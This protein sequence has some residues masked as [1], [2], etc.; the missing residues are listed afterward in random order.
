VKTQILTL[1]P[2]DDQAAARD[3][4][5]WT[6]APRVILVW[7]ARGRILNRR[8]DL[9]L[10]Q[11]QASRRGAQIGLVTLDPDIR[12]E[13]RDLGIPAFKSLDDVS[14]EAWRT[15]ALRRRQTTPS[16][17]LP[18]ADRPDLATLR[19]ALP[20]GRDLPLPGRWA[21]FSLAIIAV[22]LLGIS[23]LPSA[24]ITLMPKSETQELVLDVLPQLAAAAP[25]ATG[26]IPARQVR[27]RILGEMQQPATGQVQVPVSYASGTAIF[28]NLS[29]DAVAIPA[30][31]GVRTLSEP[32]IR[33]RTTEEVSLPAEEGATVIVPIQALM[34]GSSGNLGPGAIEAI[35]GNLG[36]Q[37]SVSNPQAIAGGKDEIRIGVAQGDLD[38]LTQALEQDLMHK[39]LQAKQAELPEDETLDEASLQ[40]T[41]V[42]GR[43]FSHAVGEA[44][45]ILRL[46]LDLEVAG[47]VYREQDLQEAVQ[48][49]LVGA[50]P[51]GRAPIP[52]SLVINRTGNEAPGQADGSFQIHAAQELFHP[53]DLGALGRAIAGKTQDEAIRLL[54][55]DFSLSVQKMRLFPAWWPRLPWLQPRMT[56][57]WSWETQ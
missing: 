19:H 41:Q 2:T 4:L 7:P 22:L 28:T 52:D 39:A 12:D 32:S 44:T 51:S 20:K 13:A 43:Q 17:S 11:R 15:R 14:E 16:L 23:L 1:E 53:V 9:A 5:T 29:Q 47:L 57:R 42:Y 25:Q 56:V 46:T 54:E 27:M 31:T 24:T 49:A 36:L 10:L 37:V 30:G 40:I 45:P 6:Q 8:L 33:F 21:I 35:D 48:L 18:P 34:P 26:V 3:K 55:Q 50:L 38:A